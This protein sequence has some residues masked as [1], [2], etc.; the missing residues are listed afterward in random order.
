MKEGLIEGEVHLQELSLQAN[1]FPPKS[2]KFR[3]CVF[4]LKENAS[5]LSEENASHLKVNFMK[6]FHK[7]PFF[8]LQKDGF[9]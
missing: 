1:C 5:V 4:S 8:L 2:Q 7:I 9:P 3:T 6:S